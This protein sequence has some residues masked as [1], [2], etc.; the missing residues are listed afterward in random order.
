MGWMLLLSPY[1]MKTG[2]YTV[3]FEVRNGI[4]TAQEFAMDVAVTDAGSRYAFN[5][6]KG[7]RQNRQL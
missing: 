7:E 3:E 1:G 4:S 6:S 2:E 5:D